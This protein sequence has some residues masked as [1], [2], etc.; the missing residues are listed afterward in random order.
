MRLPC[1][2][3]RAARAPLSI[4]TTCRLLQPAYVTTPT[5]ERGALGL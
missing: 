4:A 5:F 1:L 2:L 3:C